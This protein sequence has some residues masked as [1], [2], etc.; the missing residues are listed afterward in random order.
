MLKYKRNMFNR[1]K[2]STIYIYYI[3]KYMQICFLYIFIFLLLQRAI[4][5]DNKVQI[6]RFYRYFIYDFL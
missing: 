5:L 4:T 6:L 1:L 3:F 2:M